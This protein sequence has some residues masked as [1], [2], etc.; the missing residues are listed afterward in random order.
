MLGSQPIVNRQDGGAGEPGKRSDKSPID[1]EGSHR[2]S[3]RREYRSGD[4]RDLLQVPGPTR[5]GTPSALTGRTSMP[6][7]LGAAPTSP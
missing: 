7:R 2:P 1:A 3:R 6:S 5:P 4:L